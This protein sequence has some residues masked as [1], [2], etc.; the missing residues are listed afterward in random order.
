MT[1]LKNYF[2]VT[3]LD[4]SHFNNNNFINFNTPEDIKYWNENNA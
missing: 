4:C 2:N 3:Q 1:D